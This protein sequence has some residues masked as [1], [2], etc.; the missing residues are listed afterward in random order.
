M[1]LVYKSSL[2]TYLALPL[3]ANIELSLHM[4]LSIFERTTQSE[5]K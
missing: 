2:K 4:M 1:I 3:F 5:I